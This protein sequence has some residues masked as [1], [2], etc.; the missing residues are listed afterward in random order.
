MIDVYHHKGLLGRL[1]GYSLFG[2]LVGIR[3]RRRQ[4]LIGVGDS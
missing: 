3:F 1:L 2:I 4:G